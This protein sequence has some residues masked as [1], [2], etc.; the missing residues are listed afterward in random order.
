MSLEAALQRHMPAIHARLR[1]MKH[2][3]SVV[4]LHARL[5]LR[6]MARRRRLPPGRLQPNDRG[7]F[8]DQS[9]G[10]K[11]ARALGP[12]FKTMWSYEYTTCVVGHERA[13]RLLLANEACVPGK[14]IDLTGLFPLG[15]LRGMRGD[16]HQKYRRLLVQAMQATPFAAHEAAFRQDMLS[17]LA[18]LAAGGEGSVVPGREARR[19]LRDIA[20]AVMART[21]FGITPDMPIYAALIADY[22]QFGPEAPVYSIGRDQIE[23]FGRIRQKILDHAG[24][25]RRSPGSARQHSYLRYLVECDTLDEPVL[26]NL[27]YLL[28]AT[29]FDV[30]SLWRWLLKYLVANPADMQRVR[31]VEPVQIKFLC[32]A[33][34]HETL[35]VDQSEVL[36]R[37]PTVDIE[38]ENYLIPKGT[39]LRACL[40]EGHKDPEVFPEPFK[41]DPERFRGRSYPIEQ[42]APFGLDKRRCIAGDFV[43]DISALFVEVLL[44]NFDLRL[45]SDGPP[46]LGAFH[47]EPNPDLSITISRSQ[48]GGFAANRA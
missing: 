5:V 16:D 8:A 1:L 46:V 6:A 42:Y 44:R 17:G 45:V 11:R 9:F 7:M 26:G 37:S 12:I 30:L 4:M 22:R 40:W 31:A 10:L 14:T 23:A 19:C 32:E 36:Y 47:W 28:E 2:S 43:I 3:L 38:F 27:I 25:I 20:T 34:V 29:H 39:I 21:L 13:R 24:D 18:S 48:D 15:S 33:I 41:F 35:R